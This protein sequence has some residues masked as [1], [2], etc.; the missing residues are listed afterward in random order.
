[1]KHPSHVDWVY[2]ISAFGNRSLPFW[3][4]RFGQADEL[5]CAGAS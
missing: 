4:S 5:R 1:M 2:P 3:G